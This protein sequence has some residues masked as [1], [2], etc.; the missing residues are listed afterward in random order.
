VL[1]IGERIDR[2]MQLKQKKKIAQQIV[3]EIEKEIAGEE[4]QLI[5]LMDTQGVQRSTGSMATVSI[6]ESIK[7]SV[8]DWD[9]FYDYIK[10]HDYFHLLDR[11]PSVNGCRE[12]FEKNGMIPGV[13]PF[14]KRTVR[15][16][17]L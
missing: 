7:P 13:V 10:R 6:V 4:E 9:Q 15:T 11:R 16:T 2:L 12:L 17:S 1:T 3:E 8:Q 5:E 14:T